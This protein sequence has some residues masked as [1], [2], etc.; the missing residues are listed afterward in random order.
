MASNTAQQSTSTPSITGASTQRSTAWSIT[1]NNP[2]QSDLDSWTNASS[3]PWVIEAK[4]QVEEGEEGTP[5]IQGFLKTQ[6]VRFSQV[7]RAFPRAH[8]EVARNPAALANY[9][10]KQETRVQEL[11]QTQVATPRL[12]QTSLTDKVLE[13]LLHKNNPCTF[14][15]DAQKT[16]KRSVGDWPDGLEP[17][18]RQDRQTDWTTWLITRNKEYLKANAEQIVDEVVEHLIESGYMMVEFIM[19]NNQVRTAYK[20]YL[21]SICI[22]NARQDHQEIDQETVSETSSCVQEEL[23]DECT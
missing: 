2:T 14:T 8:I 4:G 9:V 1:I 17:T 16:W 15:R 6:Q 22:R 11:H 21:P 19:A 3:L 18:D 12:I 7:K 23:S 5:H 13:K 10:V 20:K